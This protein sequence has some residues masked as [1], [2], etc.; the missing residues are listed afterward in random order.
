MWLGQG[1]VMSLTIFWAPMAVPVAVLI[2][3]GIGTLIA[4]ANAR[5]GAGCALI[6]RTVAARCARLGH[7]YRVDETSCRCVECGN[8]VSRIDGEVYGP[9]IEGRRERRR[10]DRLTPTSPLRWG[11][12]E[13]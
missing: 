4:V 12:A 8:Y 9:A 10:E 7:A 5:G 13:V 1:T 3:I 2:V 11:R 6:Q